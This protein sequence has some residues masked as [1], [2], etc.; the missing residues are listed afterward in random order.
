[1]IEEKRREKRKERRERREEREEKRE[2][3]M[4][5]VNTYVFYKEVIFV[6]Q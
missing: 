6:L 5:L 3:D 2:D 1:M 4:K